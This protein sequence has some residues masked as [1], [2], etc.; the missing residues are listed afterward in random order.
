MEDQT[1]LEPKS[2]DWNT[3]ET[4]PDTLK[5]ILN[6]VGHVYAPALLANAQ[7]MQAGE[8][9]WEAEIDGSRWAQQTFNYQGK[10]LQWIN[11]EYQALSEADRA[12]VDGLLEGTGCEK[13]IF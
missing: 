8:K 2:N 12:R 11:A 7:A 1:G 3:A 9:A 13:I 4:A 10:C 6:E 5:G